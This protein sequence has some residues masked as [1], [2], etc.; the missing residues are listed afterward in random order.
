MHEHGLTDWRFQFDRA[1]NRFGQCDYGN[2]IISLSEPLT[3]LNSRERV[4]QTILHEVAHALTPGAGHG[5]T[6]KVKART[7]GYT[8]DRCFNESNTVLAPKKWE[9]V[10]LTCGNKA[11]RDRLTEKAKTLACRYC[12]NNLNGGRYSVAYRFRWRENRS[13]V[14]SAGILTQSA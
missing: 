3:R 8:G 1:K 6:W 9:G 12:C 14:R 10:C 7:I 13:G 11:Y 5:Y 4:R 2:R